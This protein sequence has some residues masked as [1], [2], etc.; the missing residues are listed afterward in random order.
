MYETCSSFVH[1]I[2]EYTESVIS[3]HFLCIPKIILLQ[4]RNHSAIIKVI[5]IKVFMITLSKEIAMFLGREAE[6]STLDELYSTDGFQCVIMYGRRRV[7]KT[8]LITEF[9]K[10]KQSIFYVAQEN[11]GAASLSDFSE[12][13]I[14]TLGMQGYQSSFDNWAKAFAFLG[15]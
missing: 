7:G 1:L 6:L 15:E 2:G 13:V 11:N 5:E 10:N 12:R 3:A 4:N 14:T 9:L 8:T